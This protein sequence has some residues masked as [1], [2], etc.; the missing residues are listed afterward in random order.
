[1][2]EENKNI[3]KASAKIKFTKEHVAL[4]RSKFC[5]IQSLNIANCH[6]PCIDDSY[7][8]TEIKIL[9]NKL[10]KTKHDP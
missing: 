5:N 9:A 1:M 4:M 2:R 3:K 8:L 6:I 7:K 10:L